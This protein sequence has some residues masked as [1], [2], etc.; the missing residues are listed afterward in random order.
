[1]NDW[2]EQLETGR[3]CLCNEE[4][5]KARGLLEA[6]LEGCPDDDCSIAGEIIF[7]IGRAFY[8][9]GMR[10]VAVKNMLAAMKLGAAEEH[11]ENMMRCILNEY[12]MPAQKTPLQDDRA[13]FFAVHLLRY[14]YTKRSGKFGTHA[15]RDMIFELISEAWLDFRGRYD[16]SCLA[17]QA[18]IDCYRDYVIFFPT[19]SVSAFEEAHAENNVIYADFGGETCGCGSGLPYMWCCGRILSIDELETE[20]F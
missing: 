9:M 12:G 17:T 18:K 19:Y 7:E 20:Q 15:E 10:G 3:E 16:Y 14:L 6:A 2:K 13:A 1:M 4:F 8:G 11:A 5:D